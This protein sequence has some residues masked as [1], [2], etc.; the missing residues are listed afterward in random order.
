MIK[1]EYGMLVL[2]AAMSKMDAKAI[3]DFVESQREKDRQRILDQINQFETQ[4]HATRTP[5]YQDTLFKKV[6]EIV[7]DTL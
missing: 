1:Y 7:V 3:N 2:D 5:I 4:A 6:R